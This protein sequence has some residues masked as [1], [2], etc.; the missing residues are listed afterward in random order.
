MIIGTYRKTPLNE[1][2]DTGFPDPVARPINRSSVCA[3]S[4][5]QLLGSLLN[6]RKGQMTASEVL[7]KLFSTNGVFNEATDWHNFLTM[8]KTE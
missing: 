6:C 7:A 3:L 5:L 2:N 8:A 1:R 4:G